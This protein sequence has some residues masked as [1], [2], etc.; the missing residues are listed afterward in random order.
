LSKGE[1]GRKEAQSTFAFFFL[2]PTEGVKREKKK[3]KEKRVSR[4]KRRKLNDFN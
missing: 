1:E 4:K 3:K 2:F